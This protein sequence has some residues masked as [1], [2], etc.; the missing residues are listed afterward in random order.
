V[1]SILILNSLNLSSVISI[2]LLNIPFHF[3]TFKWLLFQ[4]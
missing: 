4:F 3:F 1:K 2:L